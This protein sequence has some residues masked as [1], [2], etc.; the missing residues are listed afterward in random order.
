MCGACVAAGGEEPRT[1]RRRRKRKSKTSS[2]PG[3]HLN[4]CPVLCPCCRGPVELPC[5]TWT[6]AVSSL[7]EYPKVSSGRAC[8]ERGA[9]SNQSE[10][11]EALNRHTTSV[12]VWDGDIDLHDEEMKLSVYGLHFALDSSHVPSS[13]CLSNSS[14]TAAYTA[15]SHTRPA[16]SNGPVQPMPM[17]SGDVVLRKG[18]YYWEVDVCNSALYRIG[19]RSQ[20]SSCCW[21]FERKGV[22]FSA[23]YDGTV[24]PVCRVP[25]GI[26]TIGLFL[27]I[28]GGG[29][30]FYNALSQEHLVTLPTRFD[31]GG[32]VPAFALGQ[33]RLRIRTGLSPPP[34]VFHS[35][36]S[37]YRGAQGTDRGEWRKGVAFG[38]V[39]KV[40]QKFEELALSQ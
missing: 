1:T 22:H 34:L 19:V 38:S 35:K 36:D 11:E 16:L 26:K 30:S 40:V 23:A 28:T 8:E 10:Q 25:P 21:W 32:V 24:E 37:G 5:W 2:K 4:S 6:S 13:I 33:G 3:L 20:D 12:T 7:P 15:K 17:L 14:L 39:K 29:L 18:Q 27:N 31:P 9:E